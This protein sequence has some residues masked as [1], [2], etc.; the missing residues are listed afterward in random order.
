M[1]SMSRQRTNESVE[2]GRSDRKF[3]STWPAKRYRESDVGRRTVPSQLGINTSADEL[4]VSIRE[5][6]EWQDT[7]SHA[8]SERSESGLQTPNPPSAGSSPHPKDLSDVSRRTSLKRTYYDGGS[9]AGAGAEGAAFQMIT[10][11]DFVKI[12][13]DDDVQVIDVRGLDFEGGHIPRSAHMRV[14]HVSTKTHEI[15]E[16]LR[17]NAIRHVVFSCMYSVMRAPQCASTLHNALKEEA[18]GSGSPS[19]RPEFRIS[20][21]QRGIHGWVNRWRPEADF[22][23]MVE[24]FDEESWI[25][26]T[27][28]TV[29][30]GFVHV[31]DVIWSEKG[32]HALV[33]ALESLVEKSL[34]EVEDE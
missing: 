3:A 5:L 1:E 17:L 18:S 22:M 33:G 23:R 9:E 21:L 20:V 26:A 27:G 16:D 12:M 25:D 13:F 30:G 29:E 19:S 24:D 4:Q 10:C 32:Q 15:I 14:T 8:Q 28:T 2:D 7:Q 31:H 6:Q 34:V 11:D